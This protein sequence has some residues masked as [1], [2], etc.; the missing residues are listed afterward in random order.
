MAEVAE[1]LVVD[2]SVAAKWHLFDE[3]EGDKA[4]LL[5]KRFTQG[6][7]YLF[8]PEYIRYEVSAAIT[9]ASSG[10]KPRI[11]KGL[12]QEAIKAFLSLGIRT[13]NSDELILS[14]YPL[15]HRYGCALY[16]ALY[17]TL[18][19]RLNIPFITADRKFY[20]RIQH[21]PSIIWIGDYSPT[22]DN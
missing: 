7:T 13:L 6:R 12:A 10:Q 4:L 18:A 11:Q 17:L 3:E 21:L 2:A 19:K 15:V 9:K 14:A 8:A 5:L 22:Q 20:R 16:D 1:A